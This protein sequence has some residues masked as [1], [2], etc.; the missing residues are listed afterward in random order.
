MRTANTELLRRVEKLI[1]GTQALR[2][3]AD[4]PD[5]I[6]SA[7]Y[8]LKCLNALAD[9]VLQNKPVFGVEPWHP[10]AE[11]VPL[12]RPGE[13]LL[14]LNDSAGQPLPPYPAIMTFYRNNLTVP[15]DTVLFL[16]ALEQYK[17][18]DEKQISVN[19]SAHSLRDSEFIKTVI[20][21]MEKI[22]F[23][24]DER[25]I[26]EI[27]E[28]TAGLAMSKQALELM[29]KSGVAFAI[30]DVG[31]SIDHLLRLGEFEDIA[32]YIK[33]DRQTVCANPEKDNSLDHVMKLIAA[34]FP[35]TFIIAEGVKDV[36]HARQIHEHHPGIHYVQGL[37]LPGRDEF[38][39]EWNKAPVRAMG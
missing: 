27:H 24:W 4:T 19:I 29:R 30:D 11:N 35:D 17:N 20:T 37:Y 23:P 32:D 22:T 21:E 33:I 16:C 10:V 34:T 14:R 31:L 13:F 25:I 26:V 7:E 15:L 39:S 9:A 12:D 28:S 36:D 38:K 1:I 2:E 6:Q 18:S 5:K 3:Q 8:A